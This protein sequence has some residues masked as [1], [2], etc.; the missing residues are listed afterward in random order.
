MKSTVFI[1]C[2]SLNTRGT[3]LP[4]RFSFKTE[5]R[6]CFRQ[7]ESCFEFGADTVTFLTN[8]RAYRGHN[9]E[10]KYPELFLKKISRGDQYIL[11]KAA[12]DEVTGLQLAERMLSV[13]GMKQTA[14][15]EHFL[16]VVRRGDADGVLN[17]D[18]LVGHGLLSP[19]LNR[20]R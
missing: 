13:L 5:M 3:K 7:I 15:P 20:S 16:K 10:R 18:R 19:I 1:K 12:P 4:Y 2:N 17:V 11:I 8:V 9:I 6:R 14:N